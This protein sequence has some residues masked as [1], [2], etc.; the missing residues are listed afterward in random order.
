MGR[1]K[2]LRPVVTLR[3]CV[4]MLTGFLQATTDGIL[5]GTIYGL[6]A[7]G[8]SLVF[9][10]MKIIN[11]AH[12]ALIML[13]MYIT[14]V[15]CGIFHTNPYF[16]I[17]LCVLVMFAIG[18][19]I[20]AGLINRIIDTPS[21]NQLLL[22]L[23]LMVFIQNFALFIWS[24][25]SKSIP[26]PGLDK[27]ITIF[28]VSISCLRLTAFLIG[29][30]VFA[31][32]Y[33]MISKMMLGKEIQA[34]AQDRVAARLMGI[35]IKNINAIAFGLATA[36][37]GIAGLLITPIYYITPNIG[38][39]FLLKCFVVAILGSLGNIW[40]ALVAGIIV[41]LCES[42]TGLYIGGSWNEMI[43][44]AIFV[45]TLLVKPT[46]LFGRRESRA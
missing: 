45:I 16:I 12:G 39:T 4:F 1:S 25:D 27:A 18:Y 13:S 38:D 31:I 15:L 26:V 8:I 34:T 14:Y 5:M 37:A 2:P 29:I 9:G 28:G 22:T 19:T 20:Q 24:A 10:V 32:V 44:Y 42:M 30:V 23:G 6:M 17:P 7:L 3:S 11:F 41:G 46:G 43:V 21:H 36:C 40:G 33:L 35:K